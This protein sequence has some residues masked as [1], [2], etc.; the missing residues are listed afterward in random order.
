LPLYIYVSLNLGNICNLSI[1][2]NVSNSPLNGWIAVVMNT[3][4]RRKKQS[5]PDFKILYKHLLGHTEEN[6]KKF[7]WFVGAL[8]KI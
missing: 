6:H 1:I 2:C 7:I 5:W 4:G 3:K 8:A